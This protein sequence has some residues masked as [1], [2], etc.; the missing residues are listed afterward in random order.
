[1]TMMS[2]RVLFLIILDVMHPLHNITNCFG[3][4]LDMIGIDILDYPRN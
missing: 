3:I 4:R 1:M 2:A